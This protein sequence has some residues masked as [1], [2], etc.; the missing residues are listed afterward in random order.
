MARDASARRTSERSASAAT[1]RVRTAGAPAS[2][3]PHEPLMF[4]TRVIYTKQRGYRNRVDSR[5]ATRADLDGAVILQRTGSRHQ[6]RSED[7][8]RGYGLGQGGHTLG[9]M[10]VRGRALWIRGR[11]RCH[12]VPL[13]AVPP[14]ER[15]SCR[16]DQ[17]GL[18]GSRP[19]LLPNFAL[20]SIVGRRRA[21]VLPGL[22]QQFI[23]EA[24]GRGQDRHHR[25]HARCTDRHQADG[26]YL[27]RR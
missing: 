26:A 16:D 10:P 17:R 3:G 8:I 27:R 5:I 23:L 9:R 6:P 11:S 7:E 1:P 12:R 4:R 19:D 20:V 22:R 18:R 24:G 13:H 14:H 21:R 25:G 15:S 2:V